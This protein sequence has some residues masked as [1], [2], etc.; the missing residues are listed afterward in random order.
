MS[1]QSPTSSGRPAQPQGSSSSRHAEMVAS[2]QP[3]STPRRPK[4]PVCAKYGHK[5]IDQPP[6]NI[7]IKQENNSAWADYVKKMKHLDEFKSKLTQ[8]VYEQLSE[9]FDFSEEYS[10]LHQ[11]LTR[12]AWK[13][14]I[15]LLSVS[16]VNMINTISSIAQHYGVG[17]DV[18]RTDH[19]ADK[20]VAEQKRGINIRSDNIM[21]AN[22]LDQTAAYMQTKE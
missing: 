13:N 16:H 8:F 18:I 21:K 1:P 19:E 5:Y 7:Q 11:F 12:A 4:F 2:L 9:V 22:L 20:I 6:I 17:L 10:R 14:P 3:A 15:A